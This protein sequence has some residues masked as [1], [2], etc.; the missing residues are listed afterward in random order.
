MGCYGSWPTYSRVWRTG[1]R[2]N[3]LILIIQK[4]YRLLAYCYNNQS[5]KEDVFLLMTLF[6]SRPT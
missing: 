5:T 4:A 1:G 2:H 3:A 6:I